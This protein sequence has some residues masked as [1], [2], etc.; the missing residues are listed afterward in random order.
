[1][2]Y[3]DD[4]KIRAYAYFLQGLSYDEIAARLNAEMGISIAPSTIHNWAEKENKFGKTWHDF[5]AETRV[6]V[7]ETIEVAER[8]RLLELR[9]KATTLQERLYD[10]L[11]SETAPKV[12]SS[13]GGLYAWKALA[14]FILR[15]EQKTY[16][17]VNVVVVIQTLL[18]I[19]AEVPA[20]REAIKRNWKHI[21]REIKL[22]ILHEVPE[23]KA[24]E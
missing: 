2:A 6:L 7:R 22:R 8:N 17:Q 18:S 23:A 3:S 15:I 1:M 10:Q 9:D 21:E 14:E 19:L 16:E 24:I 12:G 4:V 20:V 13:E 11:V 5:R